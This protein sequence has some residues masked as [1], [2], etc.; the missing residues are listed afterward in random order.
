[1][2]LATTTRRA[3]LA[4]P[5]VI[6]ISMISQVLA[7]PMVINYQG[8]LT[9]AGGSPV[10]NG[11]YDLQFAI[12][13]DSL[14]GLPLWAET[15][16]VTTSDGL[17]SH[18]MGSLNSFPRDL[19]TDGNPR[20]LEL[21][22]EGEVINTRTLLGVVPY[23]LVTRDLF[24]TDSNDTLVI[25]TFADERRLSLYDEQGQERIRLQADA[26]SGG[27]LLLN[28]TDGEIG[29]ALHGDLTGD[30]SVTL[31][32]SSVNS[33]EILD[34]TGYVTYIRVSPVTLATME[35]TDLVTLEIETPADGYIVLEGKC[36]VQLSGTTGPNVALVQIDQ[37][38]GGGSQFPYY[39]LAGLGGYV[40][41]NDSY[42]P[43][44]VTRVYWKPQGIHEFRMEGRANDAPPAEARTWDHIL[45]ATYYPTSYG[46]VSK[47]SPMPGNHPEAEPLDITD[48]QNPDGP[49]R[50][51]QMDLRYFEQRAKEIDSIPGHDQR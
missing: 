18:L 21:T 19:F 43:V 5:I 38:E 40:T 44:Y 34:E 20:Y 46:V 16:T 30:E 36:Y 22:T 15:T 31:P 4:G 26:E 7:A 23:A 24:V 11:S 51:Y 45:T 13:D 14:G 2:L 17:F 12:Y 49:S 35:M 27:Q 33:A 41:T 28:R 10:A 42:F 50:Y 9:G 1:M 6:L 25:G 29:I 8:R 37:E 48:P 47:V 3:A 39:T 32:D